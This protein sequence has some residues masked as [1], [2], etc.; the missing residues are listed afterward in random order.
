MWLHTNPIIG[1][2]WWRELS[3]VRH[4]LA[5]MQKYEM[6]KVLKTL[7]PKSNNKNYKYKQ[8]N[9]NKYTNKYKTRQ[10]S[11]SATH[12]VFRDYVQQESVL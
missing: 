1:E 9:T 10:A 8:T 3:W 11:E 5:G 6:E 12:T 2:L 4:H 7:Q